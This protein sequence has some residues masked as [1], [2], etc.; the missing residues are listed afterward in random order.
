MN[1][2]FLYTQY[3]NSHV[4]HAFVFL[5]QTYLIEKHAKNPFTR[6]EDVLIG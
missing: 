4:Y 2:T 5:D 1:G 6:Y 3:G